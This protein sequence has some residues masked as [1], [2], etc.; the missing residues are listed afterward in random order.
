MAKPGRTPAAI[1]WTNSDGARPPVGVAEA[2]DRTRQI[3]LAIRQ[4]Y[5]FAFTV[6]LFED[7]PKALRAYVRAVDDR[8]DADLAI[9]RRSGDGLDTEVTELRIQEL[10]NGL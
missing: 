7:E 1:I 4:D 6:Y 3:S 8:E 2:A 10:V 5:R 9:Y